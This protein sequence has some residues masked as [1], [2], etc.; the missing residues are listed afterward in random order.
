MLYL[1]RKKSRANM[2]LFRKKMNKNSINLKIVSNQ[3]VCDLH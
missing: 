3:M 1:I 2:P